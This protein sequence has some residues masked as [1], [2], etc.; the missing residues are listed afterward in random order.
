VLLDAEG[1]GLGVADAA[2]RLRGEG[3]L[4]SAAGRA[5]HLRAVTHLDVSPGDVERAV[6]AAARALSPAVLPG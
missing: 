1:L 3:V 2:E 6:E 4:L 5:G